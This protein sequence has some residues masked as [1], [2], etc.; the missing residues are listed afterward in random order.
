MLMQ[1]H[2]EHTQEDSNLWLSQD[3]DQPEIGSC[4]W[5]KPH[6]INSPDVDRVEQDVT[7]ETQRLEIRKPIIFPI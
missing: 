1:L 4:M 7:E 2:H 5:L 3:E 6:K